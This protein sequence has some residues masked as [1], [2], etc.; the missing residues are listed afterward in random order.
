MDDP[1]R[2]V[3][4]SMQNLHSSLGWYYREEPLG[5][6]IASFIQDGYPY[7]LQPAFTQTTVSKH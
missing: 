6:A 4:V 2:Y 1:P 3:L 5:I 7:T